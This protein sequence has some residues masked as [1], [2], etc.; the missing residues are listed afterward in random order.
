MDNFHGRFMEVL[1]ASV[2]GWLLLKLV[3]LSIVELVLKLEPGPARRIPWEQHVTVG[4]LVFVIVVA[5]GQRRLATVE[6]A[7]AGACPR[8]SLT[9]LPIPVSFLLLFLL[10]IVK[11]SSSLSVLNCC[12][13]SSVSAPLSSPN[14]ESDPQLFGS[15]SWHSAE[16][17]LKELSEARGARRTELPLLPPTCS[18]L[19]LSALTLLLLVLR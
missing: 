4:L 5:F 19:P 1:I 17:I 18:G 6:G 10:G 3:V 13:S 15:V 9:L 11:L 16:D 7:T 12:R 14:T 2:S 8:R